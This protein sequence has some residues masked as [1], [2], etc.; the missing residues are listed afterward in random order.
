MIK[1]SV[2]RGYL[3]CGFEQG[4]KMLGDEERHGDA[5]DAQ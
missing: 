5:N 2:D 1:E 4:I 3:I